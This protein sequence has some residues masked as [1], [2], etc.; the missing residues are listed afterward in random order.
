LALYAY[1]REAQLAL[2]QT[3]NEKNYLNQKYDTVAFFNTTRGIIDYILKYDS[4][5]CKEGKTEAREE[6][7]EL[8]YKYYPNLNA[9]GRWFFK[10]GQFE[11]ARKFFK[12]YIDI[13]SNSIWGI[14]TQDEKAINNA[15]YLYL[16]SSFF[17][18]DYQS[19]FTYKEQALADSAFGQDVLET[20]VLSAM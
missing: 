11:D 7:Q 19:V 12:R 9:G 15:A 1:G 4:L 13:P 6:N 8:L 5:E 20:L 3:E 2:H 18:K 14:R 10:N 17:L 16:K